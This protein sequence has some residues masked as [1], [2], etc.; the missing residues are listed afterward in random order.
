MDVQ[1]P[2]RD[3]SNKP[4]G[5]SAT[6][7]EE[8][9]DEE[10]PTRMNIGPTT[11]PADS[12]DADDLSSELSDVEMEDDLKG[13]ELEDQILAGRAP[14]PVKN[15]EEAKT[16]DET[17]DSHKSDVQSQNSP[18]VRQPARALES[19]NEDRRPGLV[20]T[21][22]EHEQLR[23]DAQARAAAAVMEAVS[24]SR[25]SSEAPE[26]ASGYQAQP[27]RPSDMGGARSGCPLRPNGVEHHRSRSDNNF[28]INGG[29]GLMTGGHQLDE[30][31]KPSDLHSIL[32]QEHTSAAS[33]PK[34]SPNDPYK[35]AEAIA[36]QMEGL[37][38]RSAS[39]PIHE[40]KGSPSPFPPPPPPPPPLAPGPTRET[41][42]QGHHHSPSLSHILSPPVQSPTMMPP[43]SSS[44]TPVQA[45]MER[46]SPKIPS[47]AQLDKWQAVRTSYQTAQTPTKASFVN[48]APIVPSSEPVSKV[49]Q[50]L[51]TGSLAT[52]TTQ[53]GTPISDKQESFDVSQFRDSARGVRWSRDGPTTGFLRLT[54]DAMRGWAETVKGSPLTA[55]I[56]PNKIGRI[57]VDALDGETEKERVNL[58]HRDGNQQTLVFETN[59]ANQRLVKAAVQRRRFVTWFKKINSS[60][61]YR[62]G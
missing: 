2:I 38:S 35:R 60:V 39:A 1:S 26:A 19:Q 3:K 28:V 5:F 4:E 47:V 53:L 32:N 49:S 20:S 12:H 51:M 29:T 7:S 57:E 11:E 61:E 27:I 10:G 55:T 58:N 9:S 21:G 44:S 18:E 56:E 52:P 42:S 46:S 31:R 17:A 45:E 41:L 25:A 36:A 24:R 62:N 30:R 37:K 40:G 13:N 22:S 54:T 8:G 6:S 59:S 34:E 50:S 14:G 15:V 23:K 33:G 43:R 16:G 48:A